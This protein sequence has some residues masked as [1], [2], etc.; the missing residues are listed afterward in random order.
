M[1]IKKGFTLAEILIVLMVIGIIATMTVPGLMAGV[2]EA[3]FKTGYKKAYNTITN[4]LAMSAVDGT[5]P[6]KGGATNAAALFKILATN[7]S[8]KGFLQSAQADTAGP[9]DMQ[10]LRPA[11]TIAGQRYGSANG[12]AATFQDVTN[13]LTAAKTW[14]VTEDNMAYSVAFLATDAN[15]CGRKL[16]INALTN[17]PSTNTTANQGPCFVVIVDVNGLQKTPNSI[18]GASEVTS[19]S[20]GQLLASGTGTPRLTKDQYL[21]YVGS[22]GATAGNPKL[23]LTGRLIAD[24]K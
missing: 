1:R 19:A 24:I 16:D 20:V 23:T 13:S 11:V 14:I 21:I 12:T 9:V 18:Q 6:G 5:L 15:R 10:D 8:V 4:L 3:Q 7:L 2:Q 22:D 17:D